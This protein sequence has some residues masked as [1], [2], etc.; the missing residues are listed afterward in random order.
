MPFKKQAKQTNLRVSH[1]RELHSK[2]I[3]KSLSTELLAA[4]SKFSLLPRIII[5]H[6]S[7]RK[8]AHHDTSD[9]IIIISRIRALHL[10]L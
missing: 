5:F 6:I 3:L 4:I 8:L 1:V 7:M 10:K 2:P 9:T